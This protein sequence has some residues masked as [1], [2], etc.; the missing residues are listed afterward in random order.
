MEDSDSE[1]EYYDLEFEIEQFEI[2]YMD[3]LLNVYYDLQSRYRYF[4]QE[5][6]FGHFINLVISVIFRTNSFNFE[7]LN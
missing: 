3:A 1:S 6:H 4:L 5:M 7:S 2:K